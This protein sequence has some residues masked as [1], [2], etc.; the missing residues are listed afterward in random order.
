M[1]NKELPVLL[2]QIKG[3]KNV[4]GQIPEGLIEFVIG[5]IHG[6]FLECIHDFAVGLMEWREDRLMT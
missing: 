5:E 1:D 2:S 6:E 3:L 4:F